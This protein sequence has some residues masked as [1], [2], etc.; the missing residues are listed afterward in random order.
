VKEVKTVSTSLLAL[1]SEIEAGYGLSYFD[2]L[3]AASALT[4][5]HRVVSDDEAFDR[6][7]DFERVPITRRSAT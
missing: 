1:Q 3:I 5:D 4:L 6:I 7:P 2:S